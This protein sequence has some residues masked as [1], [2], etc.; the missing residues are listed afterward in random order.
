[1]IVAQRY[2]TNCGHELREED[3]FCPSCGRPVHE[4][5]AVSTPEADVPVPLPPSQRIEGEDALQAEPPPHRSMANKLLLFGCMG[6]GLI[7]V[8]LALVVGLA[9]VASS[10]GGGSE[11]AGGGA[12]SQNGARPNLGGFGN[13]ETFTNR[14]YAEPHSD[15]KAH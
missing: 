12:N 1:V 10:G 11:S 8:L 4:T 6:L 15:P 5:A 7:T 2:C 14:N 3:R 9:V 13:T